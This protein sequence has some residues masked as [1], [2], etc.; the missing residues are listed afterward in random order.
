MSEEL[1]PTPIPALLT[2]LLKEERKKGLPLT[3]K[4]VLAIRDNA[5]CMMLSLDRKILL[6]KSRGYTD[7]DPERVWEDWQQARIESIQPQPGENS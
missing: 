1:V 2:I 5:V 7:L 3:E 6:E 4:E